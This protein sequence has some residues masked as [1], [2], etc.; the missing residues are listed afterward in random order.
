MTV[1]DPT[2]LTA[3]IGSASGVISAACAILFERRHEGRDADAEAEKTAKG[4][5][6]SSIESWTELNKALNREIARLHSDVDRIRSDYETAMERQRTEYE[7]AMQRQRTEYET[8]LAADHRRIT[9][10]ETDVASLR[11][12][13]S[14]GQRDGT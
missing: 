9:D 14:P 7:A 10:L 2:A 12:L 6:D 4:L 5:A 8:Q 11:R 3:I 13:L 1:A